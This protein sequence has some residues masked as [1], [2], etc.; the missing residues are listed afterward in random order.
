M[1]CNQG[2]LC[3]YPGIDDIHWSK[4]G[5]L[6][7]VG[8]MSGAEFNNLAQ[9]LKTF[10]QTFPYYETFRVRNSSDS[11]HYQQWFG[12]VDCASY[13]QKFFCQAAKYGA[14]FVEDYLPDYTYITLYSNEPKLLGNASQIFGADG[15]K[16]LAED[17]RAFYS[18]FRAHQPTLK[19]VE[20]II[21]ILDYVLIK[22]EFYFFFNE[23][24]WLLPMKEPFLKIHND[25]VEFEY[26]MK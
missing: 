7:K 5:T 22:K 15:D 12:P 17:I 10:N 4:Y 19:F 14:K 1:W 2:A 26:C 6:K 11:K 20:S 25:P 16:D 13:V 24:Y 3:L 9:Y 23:Q 8:D 21:D 18:H